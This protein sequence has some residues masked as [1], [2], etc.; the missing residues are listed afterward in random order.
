MKTKA[1]R[2]KIKAKHRR[3]A[4]QNWK[5]EKILNMSDGQLINALKE[6]YLPTFGTKHE[7]IER[8]KKHLGLSKRDNGK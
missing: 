6:K 1:D 7:R 8:L 4:W 2:N 5:L 3:E